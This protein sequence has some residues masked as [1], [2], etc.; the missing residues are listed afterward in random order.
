MT[1]KH[2]QH[3]LNQLSK[4]LWFVVTKTIVSYTSRF[5]SNSLWVKEFKQNSIMCEFTAT[6]QIYEYKPNLRL[7]R[8]SPSFESSLHIKSHSPS[9]TFPVANGD[10]QIHITIIIRFTNNLICESGIS[11]HQSR[12]EGGGPFQQVF[13]AVG[14]AMD[15]PGPRHSNKIINKS[16]LINS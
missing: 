15:C 16:N 3:P 9:Q 7:H 1:I 2:L 6:N 5:S 13:P 8:F 10:A 14:S 4:W 11:F 12:C